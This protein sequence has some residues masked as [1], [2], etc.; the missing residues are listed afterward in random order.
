MKKHH[1]YLERKDRRRKSDPA[2]RHPD[3]YCGVPV[4]TRGGL[5]REA[6]LLATIDGGVGYIHF[7]WNPPDAKLSPGK[8]VHVVV[9]EED[10]V[11]KL[12]DSFSG[13]EA[14]VSEIFATEEFKA[15]LI[16]YLKVKHVDVLQKAGYPLP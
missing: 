14:A 10:G 16:E 11:P 6:R 5:D 9:Q 4:L 3:T 12:G 1:D 8:V 15:G 2:N 13:E 7:F